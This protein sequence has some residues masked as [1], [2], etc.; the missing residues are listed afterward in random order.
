MLT[1][2][3]SRGL[4]AWI[5]SY[6]QS[7]ISLRVVSCVLSKDKRSVASRS[8]Y[9]VSVTA[10]IPLLIEGSPLSTKGQKLYGISCVAS[11]DGASRAMR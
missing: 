11:S 5:A 8:A 4:K 9:S 10:P 6:A 7:S 3:L 2:A 1:T